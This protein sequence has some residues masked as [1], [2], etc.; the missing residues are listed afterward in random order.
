MAGMA[1]ENHPQFEEW[2]AALDRLTSLRDDYASHKAF[3]Y[4]ANLPA[5]EAAIRE[6]M[7]RFLDLSDQIDS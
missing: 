7:R 2:S 6:A 3:G 5:K 4:A 1:I